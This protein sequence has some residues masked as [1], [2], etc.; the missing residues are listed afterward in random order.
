MLVRDSGKRMSKKNF[1]GP[2]LSMRAASTSS[3]GTVMG[4]GPQLDVDAPQMYPLYAK[5]V[6]LDIACGLNMGVPGPRLPMRPQHV[7]RLGARLPGAVPGLAQPAERHVR[8]RAVGACI[9][10]RD[11]GADVAPVTE[12][13]TPLQHAIKA[14]RF[15]AAELLLKRGADPDWQDYLRR[16]GELGALVSLTNK[17]MMPVD[18]FDPPKR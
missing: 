18:F 11:A 8:L 1:I 16:S 10:H 2:A 13:E 6:E 7:E 17:L 14:G 12:D 4:N 3:S 9:H 5:C 15:A